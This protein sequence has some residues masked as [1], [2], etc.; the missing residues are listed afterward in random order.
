MKVFIG[1]IMAVCEIPLKDEGA[2][3]GTQIMR[4]HSV[5]QLDA[6]TR[7]QGIQEALKVALARW[8]EAE[9]YE[10]HSVAVCELEITVTLCALIAEMAAQLGAEHMQAG[11]D[12]MSLPYPLSDEFI[13]D[14]GQ[15]AR[16]SASLASVASLA[17][18][19]SAFAWPRAPFPAFALMPN[20]DLVAVVNQ[21]MKSA[22]MI[23]KMALV[24]CAP[25]QIG[26]KSLFHEPSASANNNLPPVREPDSAR[27]ASVSDSLDKPPRR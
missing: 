14:M 11:L 23:A 22:G 8:P 3:A 2:D 19:S 27:P 5:V 9:G 21:A 10:E 24:A 17:A 4:T 25:E 15:M 13:K 18:R 16:S 1:S 20:M 6:E 12:A 26:V 7:E